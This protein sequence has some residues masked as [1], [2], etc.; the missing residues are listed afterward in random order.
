MIGLIRSPLFSPAENE[1]WAGGV[2]QG[3]QLRIIMKPEGCERQTGGS[4][5]GGMAFNVMY[6]Y[7]ARQAAS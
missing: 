3:E 2:Q 1:V 4:L 6:V 5:M 7:A